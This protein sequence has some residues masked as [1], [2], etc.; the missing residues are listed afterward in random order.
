MAILDGVLSRIVLNDATASGR[1]H[2]EHAMLQLCCPTRV[3]VFFDLN[4][5]RGS[6]RRMNRLFPQRSAGTFLDPNGPGLTFE[7]VR[8]RRVLTSSQ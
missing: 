1:V 5:M 4:S 3:F 7:I 2:Y 6:T 8:V